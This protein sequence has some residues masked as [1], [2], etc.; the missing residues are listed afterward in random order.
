MAVGVAIER[1]DRN[2]GTQINAG[3][4]LHLGRDFADHSAQ[5]PDQRR[6]GALGDSHR[7]T[8]LATD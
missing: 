1:L 7:K 2:P 8:E 5:R 6:V 4:A 3:V